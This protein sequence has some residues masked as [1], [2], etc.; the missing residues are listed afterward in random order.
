MQYKCVKISFKY[1]LPQAVMYRKT[2]LCFCRQTICHIYTTFNMVHTITDRN[3]M[4]K[5]QD[6]WR[7]FTIVKACSDGQTDTQTD[8][9][10]ECI[11]TLKRNI[12]QTLKIRREILEAD[13]LFNW[14]K[15][16]QLLQIY[17]KIYPIILYIVIVQRRI[18]T[19]FWWLRP[20]VQ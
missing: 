9:E 11:N 1:F 5:F 7:T 6:I 15:C 18:Y 17:G 16:E 19:P 4:Y 8:R 14:G 10:I 20:N 12:S 3:N 2:F 13:F